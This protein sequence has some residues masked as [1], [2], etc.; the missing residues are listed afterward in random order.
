[1][2]TS[3]VSEP[4]ADATATGHGSGGEPVADRQPVADRGT[5]LSQ[6]LAAGPLMKHWTP[7]THCT[8]G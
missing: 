7:V 5:G 2:D 4:V 6:R 8:P 1:M 3:Q